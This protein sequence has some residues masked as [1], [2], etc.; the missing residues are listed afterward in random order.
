[1]IAE[2]RHDDVGQQPRSSHTAFDG[3]GRS[4]SFDNAITA[5]AGVLRSYVPDDLEALGNILQ[6]LGDIVS[7]VPQLTSTIRATVVSGSVGNDLSWKVIGKRLAFGSGITT[8]VRQASIKESFGFSRGGL[9]FFELELHL[10]KLDAELL[11]AR[12]EEHVA[13]LIHQHL[14]V[15]DLL[16]ARTEIGLMR[17]ESLFELGFERTYLLLSLLKGGIELLLLRMQQG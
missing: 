10:V 11:A 1:M 13:E 4:W 12:A 15:L 16:I 3:P 2:L 5:G 6:L 9:M 14:E 8:E 7:E 17:A